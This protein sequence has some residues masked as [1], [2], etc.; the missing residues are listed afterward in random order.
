MRVRD[1]QPPMIFNCSMPQSQFTRL[2]L[3]RE[4]GPMVVQMVREIEG[5]GATPS[6]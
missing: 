5:Q 4:V 1:H 6:A 3:E 2:Q